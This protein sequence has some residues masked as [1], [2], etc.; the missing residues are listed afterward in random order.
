[1]KRVFPDDTWPAVWRDCYGYD[2]AE[3]YGE[4][5]HRGYANAYANRRAQTLRLVASV[6]EPRARILDVAA[7]QGNFTL[8]LAEKGYRVTWNDLRSE[9]ADYVRLKHA[10]GE[11]DY[12]PGNVFELPN[13][14][15][16]DAAIVTEVIEH[17]AHPD[18]FLRN[19]A[20]LVRRGGYIVMTTPNG[21]YF[22]NDLPKF[23]DCADPS[24]F[25]AAQ[26]RPNADGHIFLLHPAEIERL[27]SEAGLETLELVHFTNPITA[28]YLKTEALLRVLPQ[29]RIDALERLSARLP[30]GIR[31]K[32]LV[33]TAALLRVR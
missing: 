11:V 32:L 18:Q 14:E 26:F 25:E 19:V 9:L 5:D 15:P 20:R 28:G 1:M 12:A 2:L 4:P 21:A 29:S 10:F 6:L 22:K 23:S 33:H 3:V 24:A 30:A 13:D 17:V 27:A 31:E 16:F 8:A 7:A